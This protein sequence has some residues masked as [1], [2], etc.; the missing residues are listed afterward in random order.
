MAVTKTFRR[1]RVLAKIQQGPIRYADLAGSHSYAI[2]KRLR[3]L[4]D[5]LVAEGLIRETY[6]D[7]FPYYVA[8]DWELTDEQRLEI[9]K[10]RCKP[11][12]GCMVWTGY[13]DPKRGPI[14]RFGDESPTPARRAAWQIKRGPLGYQQTV[15]MQADCEPDCIEY[16]HMKLGRRE[17]PAKGKH[18]SVLHRQRIAQAHQVTRGKLDWEKVRV[19]RASTKSD[20]VM[21]EQFGVSKA[22]IGQVRRGET[23]KEFGGLF[24]SLLPGRAF[25]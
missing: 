13:V 22:T 7:R 17:D 25:A 1:D 20:A 23:W 19:I 2:R 16:T 15:R 21:A 3:P 11:V 5:R 6:I 12:H 10:G 24:T 8:A 18:I 4:I 14:V 9:M